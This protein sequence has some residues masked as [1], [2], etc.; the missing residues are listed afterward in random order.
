MDGGVS[1]DGFVGG[2]AGVET[3]GFGVNVG[4]AGTWTEEDIMNGEEVLVGGEYAAVVDIVVPTD[5]VLVVDGSPVGGVSAGGGFGDG[6][7]GTCTPVD[8]GFVVNVG[9]GARVA[10]T[11]DGV[12]GSGGSLGSVSAADSSPG[13]ECDEICVVGVSDD[14]LPVDVTVDDTVEVVD[15]GGLGGTSGGVSTVICFDARV[16]AGGA[17]CRLTGGTGAFNGNGCSVGRADAFPKRALDVT[18]C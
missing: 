16:V 18:L 11:S 13:D 4:G 8:V 2:D 15:I 1:A 5:G 3:R 6:G 9:R 10:G 14:G 17:H 12:A 7:D